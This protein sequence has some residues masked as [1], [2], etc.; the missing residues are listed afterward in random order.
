MSAFLPAAVAFT[1]A[2]AVFVSAQGAAA[3]PSPIEQVV[4]EA[5]AKG[6]FSGVVRISKAGAPP[7]VI[8]AGEADRAAHQP[9]RAEQRFRLASLTKTVTAVLVLQAVDE[10]RLKLDEPVGDAFKDLP[11][12]LRAVTPRQL[13]QHTSGLANPSD[14]SPDDQVPP[15][16]ARRGEGVDDHQANARGACSGPAKAAPGAG[17]SYNNCDYILLG[18]LLER[19]YGQP[20][21]K[22]LDARITRPLG[23]SWRLAPSTPAS[24]DGV[25]IGYGAKG[26]VEDFQNV[27]TYGAAGALIGTT[28][29][30]ARFDAALMSGRLLKP[31][32]LKAL[33]TADPKLYGEALSVWVY[34]S[35]LGAPAGSP[36][37]KAHV[38]ERQGDIGGT[39]L[40]NLVIPA[41]NTSIVIAANTERADLFDTYS[42]KGLGY[43]I[44]RAAL[45]P[46][47]P[48]PSQT[49]P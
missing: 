8:L 13:L 39:R 45:S 33:T 35:D 21:A 10:G 18:A 12:H 15:F 7:V 27:A 25:A 36:P 43:A 47:S 38:W 30:V 37:R 34:D 23:L 11:A 9:I 6:D 46:A 3:A 1:G 42:R 14:G 19:T 28:D 48:P 20:F 2:A 49:K 16:Y 24:R 4:R 44:L 26:E 29:D 5:S 17:F 31:E 41:E 22:L 32:S 40:L